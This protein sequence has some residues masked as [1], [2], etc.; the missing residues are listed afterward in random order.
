MASVNSSYLLV[1]PESQ[2]TPSQKNTQNTK[3]IEKSIKFTS[4][5]CG[6]PEHGVYIELTLLHGCLIT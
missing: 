3:Y 5:I 2:I 6:P 1:P 4:Q